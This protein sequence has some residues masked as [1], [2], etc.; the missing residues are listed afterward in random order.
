[1]IIVCHV[2]SLLKDRGYRSRRQL[3]LEVGMS[4]WAL[5]FLARNKYKAVSFKTVKKLC[6]ALDCQPGDIF[7]LQEDCPCL[8]ARGVLKVLIRIL[9]K[10]L[11][12]QLPPI[13]ANSLM[14]DIIISRN[15]S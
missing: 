6:A 3:A 15:I 11:A 12:N 10:R 7:T 13:L 5:G 1:M 2:D 8:D 4:P 9:A 14:A